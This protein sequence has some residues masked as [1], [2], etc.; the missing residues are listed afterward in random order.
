M[1]SLASRMRGMAVTNC[2]AVSRRQLHVRIRR[3][4]VRASRRRLGAERV[5]KSVDIG[6]TGALRRV[7]SDGVRDQ[8][9]K[10]RAIDL[11]DRGTRQ[12]VDNEELL[13]HC[14]RTDL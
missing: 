9:G 11:A 3:M 5:R 13:Q 14:P 6:Q 7:R 1:S 2:V 4:S 8:A 10:A 12:G